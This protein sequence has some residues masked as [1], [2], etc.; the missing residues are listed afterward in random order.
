ME[1]L[2]ISEVLVSALLSL[3]SFPSEG[4]LLWEPIVEAHAARN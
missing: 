1:V 4:L 3:D 2:P